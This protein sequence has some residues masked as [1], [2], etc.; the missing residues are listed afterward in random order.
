MLHHTTPRYAK[1]FISSSSRGGFT[2]GVAYSF[3]AGA[4]MAKLKKVNHATNAANVPSKPV[5]RASRLI[6]FG[7][8]SLAGC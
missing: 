7:S 8:S 2:I 4:A 1:S 5:S 6:H 3:F